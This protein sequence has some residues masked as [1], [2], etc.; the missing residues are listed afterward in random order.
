VEGLNLKSQKPLSN[1]A[2]SLRFVG[3]LGRRSYSHL[4]FRQHQLAPNRSRRPRVTNH[5]RRR[6]VFIIMMENHR[7]R[8][9]DRQSE[10]RRSSIFSAAPAA[11]PTNLR[12]ATPAQPKN[13]KRRK[14][15]GV[16]LMAVATTQTTTTID[17]QY[18]R[19]NWKS[20]EEGV[21]GRVTCSPTRSARRRSLTH[22]GK[23]T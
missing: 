18:R 1:Q 17:A 10:L 15:S 11:W 6:S 2:R 12:Q 14:L 22:C 7:L 23:T 3:P 5:S 13:Y 8:P 20:H 9:T 19:P 21:P 4:L 16:P